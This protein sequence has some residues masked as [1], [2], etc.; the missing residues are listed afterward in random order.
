MGEFGELGGQDFYQTQVQLLQS[1]TLAERTAAA[2]SL[3]RDEAF[4]QTA[5]PSL[6]S[7]ITS[8]LRGLII[9]GETPADA[10]ASGEKVDAGGED[11]KSAARRLQD[12]LDIQLLRGSRIA[13]ISFSHPNPA[14]AQRVA[15]GYAETFITDNLDRRFEATAYARKFLEERLAQLSA[16]AP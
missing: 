15:N 10:E 16:A 7:M 2:L 6:I 8:N 5:A 12:D 1:R 3:S 14:V 4:N 13:T 11:N 9:A